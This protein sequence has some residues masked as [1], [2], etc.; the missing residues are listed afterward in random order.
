M[1]LFPFFEELADLFLLL[2][3]AVLTFCEALIFQSLDKLRVLDFEG[4]DWGDAESIHTISVSGLLNSVSG[5]LNSVSG[6][7]NSVSGL[8]NSVSDPLIL[9]VGCMFCPH[10]NRRPSAPP[11]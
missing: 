8:L 6:L 7:L 9:G 11:V 10:P 4:G 1:R 5:L 2:T 3:S